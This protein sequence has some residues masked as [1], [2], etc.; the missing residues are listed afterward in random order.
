MNCEELNRVGGMGVNSQAVV[1][2]ITPRGL[3]ENKSFRQWVEPHGVLSRNLAR[4]QMTSS[5]LNEWRER[6]QR[7]NPRE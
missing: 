3:K 4:N 7:E 6:N 2:S 1:I 5:R